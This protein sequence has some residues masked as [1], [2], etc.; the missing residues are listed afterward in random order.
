M[1]PYTLLNI[2]SPRLLVLFLQVHTHNWPLY[3]VSTASTTKMLRSIMTTSNAV[4]L[5][6]ILA[7]TTT[8]ATP[9]EANT[10][11]VI[12]GVDLVAQDPGHE[13]GAR[14]ITGKL[15]CGNFAN[16]NGHMAV[17]LVSAL[18]NSLKGHSYPVAAHG[19]NRVNC[20]DTSGVYVCNVSPD[21]PF[22]SISPP[23]PPFVH[24]LHLFSPLLHPCLSPITIC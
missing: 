18:G 16:A 11:A 14:G 23:L 17:S 24:P 9:I 21:L 3:P 19:C 6:A 15:Y 2:V 8:L 7:A 22:L 10:T 5:L 20:W 1:Y 12:D 4:L 13:L